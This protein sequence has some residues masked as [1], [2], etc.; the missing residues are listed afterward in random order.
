MDFLF[1][2]VS[3][4]EKETIKKQAKSVID[5]F[6]KKL[7]RVSKKVPESLVERDKEER[8]EREGKEEIDENFSRE[9]MFENAPQKNNDFILSEKKKW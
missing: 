6:S 7:S 1:H 8:D 5:S 4:R 2:K 3:E 9:I